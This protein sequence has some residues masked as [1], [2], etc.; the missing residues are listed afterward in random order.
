M[1]ATEAIDLVEKE[2]SSIGLTDC[3][4]DKILGIEASGYIHKHFPE[5][6]SIH[7]RCQIGEITYEQW[8]NQCVEI[9]HKAR[10]Q[11]LMQRAEKKILNLQKALIEKPTDT[12][13]PD[14]K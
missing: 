9:I 2:M 10:A 3:F 1:T 13:F 12:E 14:F 6:D 7:E 8:A 11:Y 4:G 5:Y